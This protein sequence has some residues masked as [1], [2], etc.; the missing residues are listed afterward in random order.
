M[1]RCLMLV[2]LVTA[3][4]RRAAARRGRAACSSRACAASASSQSSPRPD[5]RSSDATTR[6]VPTLRRSPRRLPV[7]GDAPHM[8]LK[9]LSTLRARLLRHRCVV[10]LLARHRE[11]VAHPRIDPDVGVG[12]SRERILEAHRARYLAHLVDVLAHRGAVDN[13]GTSRALFDNLATI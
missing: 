4:C 13:S 7:T 6:T 8:P 5:R 12:P 1:A 3:G 11:V 9:Q 10:A 2:P